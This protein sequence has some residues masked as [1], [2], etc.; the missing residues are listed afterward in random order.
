MNNED[1]IRAWEAGQIDIASAIVNQSPTP[2]A[3]PSVFEEALWRIANGE[4]GPATIAI[5]ALLTRGVKPRIT[6]PDPLHPGQQIEWQPYMGP[7]S[8]IEAELNMRPPAP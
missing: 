5:Q 6:R 3:E 8:A 7:H 4:P 2:A 1:Q